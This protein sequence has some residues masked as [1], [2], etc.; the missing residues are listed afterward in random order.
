[1]RHSKSYPR[2][3]NPMSSKVSADEVIRIAK[4]S[5]VFIK[6]DEIVD[7]QKKF[8][9]LLEHFSVLNEAATEGVSPLYAGA[10]KMELRPDEPHKGL[11][12]KDLLQNAPDSYEG[13]FRIPKV[14]EQ[15]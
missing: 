7:I 10:D 11:A 13:S 14:I 8:E 3:N 6:S 15:E 12:V 5:R 2:L 1:M 9:S 4:L